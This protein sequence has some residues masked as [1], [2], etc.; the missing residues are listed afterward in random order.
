MFG[1]PL[2]TVLTF[3]ALAVAVVFLFLPK[4]ARAKLTSPTGPGRQLLDSVEEIGRTAAG[5]HIEDA[6]GLHHAR[7]IAARLGAAFGGM[8]PPPAPTP[9]TPPASPSVP[10]SPP[11]V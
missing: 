7:E 2:E 8:Q 10:T 1:F 9:P 3:A 5:K 4:G 6:L 11:N